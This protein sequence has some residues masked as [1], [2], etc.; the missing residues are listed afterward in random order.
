MVAERDLLRAQEAYSALF[1]LGGDLH[2]YLTHYRHGDSRERG[3]ELAALDM[4]YRARGY[5]NTRAEV[6]DY[7]PLMLELAAEAG[8]EGE[9]LLAEYAPVL[10]ELE[11]K[12][13]ERGSPYA[14]AFSI[15]KRRLGA[16]MATG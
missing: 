10:A 15:L 6:P 11:A 5:E 4:R 9:A 13:A 3:Q 8:E 2:L 12:L 14:A 7:L 1:D 16:P